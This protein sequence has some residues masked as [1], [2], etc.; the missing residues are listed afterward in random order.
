MALTEKL[1]NIANAIRSKTNKSEEMTLEQMA[2]E[3]SGIDVMQGLDLMQIGYSDS[4]NNFINQDLYI[5]AINYAKSEAEL[6]NK[7]TSPTFFN[8][9]YVHKLNMI[10]FPNIDLSKFT[11]LQSTFNFSGLL[12][13]DN[14]TTY[15]ST[16]FYRCFRQT[17]VRYVRCNTDKATTLEG[18]FENS[19]QLKLIELTSVEHVTSFKNTFLCI[20]LEEIKFI[21]W[22]QGDITMNYTSMHKITP[23]SI[24]YNIQN[25]VD[26]ID[27]AT[28]RILYL[29]A[30]I[31]TNW[32]NSEYYEQDLAVL[33]QKG[34]TIA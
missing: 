27:G 16:T 32:E 9:R 25:A 1:K 30:T 17:P 7:S 22:K 3:V 20:N 10:Y 19:S 15:Q 2:S 4:Y 34:I 8:S 5:D 21:R 24:H 14:S 23:E 12:Y 29:T 11:S 33:E 13:F 6:I 28:A 26:M 18:C 31:K